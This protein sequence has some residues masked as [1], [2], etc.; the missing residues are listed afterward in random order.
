MRGNTPCPC[1]SGVKFKKSAMVR[2]ISIIV[3]ITVMARQ[4]NRRVL[5]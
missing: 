4:R 5:P 1:G 3:C 2:I